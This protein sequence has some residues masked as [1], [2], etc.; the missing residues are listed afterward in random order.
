MA[1]HYTSEHIEFQNG[2]HVDARPLTL[3]N[4]KK[5]MNLLKAHYKGLEH[6]Q[7]LIEQAV[8]DSQAAEA[9][10][11]DT[12][13]IFD[14]LSAKTDDVDDPTSWT[15]TL[16]AGSLIALR[17]YKVYDKDEQLI[18]TL[19][20]DYIENNMDVPTMTRICEIA[21]T[22]KINETED[23]AEKKEQP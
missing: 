22:M 11:E 13:P 8:K 19:N 21:G 17:Q 20:S 10:G 18:T 16:A 2:D 12:Q 5:F 15:N 23:E 9:A 6:K 7:K 1:K 3:A 14:E 4:L